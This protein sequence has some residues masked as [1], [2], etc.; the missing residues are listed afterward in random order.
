M[1]I[2]KSN[3]SDNKNKTIEIDKLEVE[4]AKEQE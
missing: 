2:P 3:E 4:D 1:A